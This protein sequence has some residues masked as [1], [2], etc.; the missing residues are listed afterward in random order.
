MRNFRLTLLSRQEIS[1]PS[2]LLHPIV[3]TV[4]PCQVQETEPAEGPDPAQL[5]GVHRPLRHRRR[6]RK[7]FRGGLQGCERSRR[8]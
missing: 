6:P 3:K 5:P 2:Q 7:P 8:R 1:E 4:D